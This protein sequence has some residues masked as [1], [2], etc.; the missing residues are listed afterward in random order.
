MGT[1]C[2]RVRA[3]VCVCA[4]ILASFLILEH[5]RLLSTFPPVISSAWQAPPP[6]PPTLR[7][8]PPCFVYLLTGARGLPEPHRGHPSGHPRHPSTRHLAEEETGLR[9]GWAGG[10]HLVQGKGAEPHLSPPAWRDE[11]VGDGICPGFGG[12]MLLGSSPGP[13]LKLSE[14]HWPTWGWG[15]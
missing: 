3:R 9:G 5:P 8:P 7:L 14:P 10:P 12:Q 1:G 15:S 13:L 2:A 11:V 6:A 4:R